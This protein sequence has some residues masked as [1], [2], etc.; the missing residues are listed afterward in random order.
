VFQRRDERQLIAEL[1]GPVIVQVAMYR[2]P[3]DEHW[4]A[5]LVDIAI[6]D[7]CTNA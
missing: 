3:A 7:R 6:D 1:V 4:I 5:R 2:I